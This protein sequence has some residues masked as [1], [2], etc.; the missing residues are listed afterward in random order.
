LINPSESGVD[1]LYALDTEC[2]CDRVR[3]CTPNFAKRGQGIGI[4]RHATKTLECAGEHFRQTKSDVEDL[5][6]QAVSSPAAA[7]TK[8]R[9]QGGIQIR[10]P[11]TI[12]C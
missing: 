3:Y 9:N 5:A 12:A 2:R 10:R 11:E 1:L 7:E 8:A 4:K 6:R